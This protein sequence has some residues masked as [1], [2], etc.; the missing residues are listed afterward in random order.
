MKRSLYCHSSACLEDCQRRYA[1]GVKIRSGF[2]NS[3]VRRLHQPG[4]IAPS[5]A[6]ANEGNRS[7][8]TSLTA[9]PPYPTKT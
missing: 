8:K 7:T 3:L 4:R 1:L 2:V 5:P 9:F 6:S